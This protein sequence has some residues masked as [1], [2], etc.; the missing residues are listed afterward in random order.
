MLNMKLCRSRKYHEIGSASGI[1]MGTESNTA[2]FMLSR[3]WVMIF[4]V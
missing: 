2:Y 4:F 3:I 1:N